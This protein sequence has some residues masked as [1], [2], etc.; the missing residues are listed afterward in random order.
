MY[1]RCERRYANREY[2][3]FSDVL[4]DFLGATSALGMKPPLSACFAVA[5]PITE[6][7]IRLTNLPW[8]M[9]ATALE[10]EFS[11]PVVKLINDFEAVALSVEVLAAD[12]LVVP[13]NGAPCATGMRVTLGAGTGM[14]VAWLIWQGGATSPC[15]PKPGIWISAPTDELQVRLWIIYASILAMYRSSA[16]LSGLGTRQYFQFPHG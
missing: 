12:D 7:G 10:R 3:S 4:R 16:I 13:Q 14:G 1:V 15:P 11:I 2:L 5:G 6:Q 8:L 9:N